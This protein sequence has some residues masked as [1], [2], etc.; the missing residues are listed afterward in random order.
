M[1]S[2]SV[3]YLDKVGEIERRVKAVKPTE[4]AY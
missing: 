2:P 4:G 3:D 1:T